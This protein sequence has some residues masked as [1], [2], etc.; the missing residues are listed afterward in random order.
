[1]LNT[2]MTESKYQK[3]VEMTKNNESVTAI[4]SQLKLTEYM[5]YKYFNT[6]FGLLDV[7]KEKE[8]PKKEIRQNKPNGYTNFIDIILNVR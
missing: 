3:F 2:A 8:K 6:Y 4:K 1:M 7:K 5:Y